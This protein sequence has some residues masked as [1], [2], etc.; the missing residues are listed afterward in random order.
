M[1]PINSPIEKIVALETLTEIK[2]KN[3]GYIVFTE[4]GNP[5]VVHKPNCS[6]VNTRNFNTRAKIN[7]GQSG[8][9]FWVIDAELGRKVFK[10]HECLVCMR[11]GR[12]LDYS[13]KLSR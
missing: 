6:L 10:A 7:H 5:S 3:R 11:P 1:N 8:N 9:F 13:R 2:K 4:S 12:N